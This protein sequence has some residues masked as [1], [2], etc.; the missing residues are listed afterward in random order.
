AGGRAEMSR[1]VMLLY[2]T[3]NSFLGRSLRP[4]LFYKDAYQH[5]GSGAFSVVT[6]RLHCVRFFALDQ[7]GEAVVAPFHQLISARPQGIDVCMICDLVRCCQL[8]YANLYLARRAGVYMCDILRERG[9][10]K[11]N[12]SEPEH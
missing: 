7:A 10:S 6:L 11:K 5:S 1:L 8:G 4:L 12:Q 3:C 9:C 2:R